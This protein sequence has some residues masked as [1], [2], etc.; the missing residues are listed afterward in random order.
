MSEG[1]EQ[2]PARS[3]WDR[4]KAVLRF[5]PDIFM[6]IAQDNSATGQACVVFGVAVLLSCLWTFPIVPIAW[7]FGFLGI[8][9]MT[10]LFMLLA[11]MFAGGPPSEGVA[12]SHEPREDR[13]DDMLPYSGWLR[14]I[15]FASVPVAFGV[16]PLVGTFIGAIFS[17]I[18]EIVAI[19]ELSGISTGAAVMTWLIAVLVPGILLIVSVMLFGFWM[20]GIFGLNELLHWH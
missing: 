2:R 14:A 6:E 4:V 19:R 8:A 20:L 1:I 7:L 18:L 15:L 16:V 5:E 11:R 13:R 17:L 10:G 9:I 12:E 3:A